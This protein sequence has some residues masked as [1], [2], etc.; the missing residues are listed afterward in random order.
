[1]L[2]LV[3]GATLAVSAGLNAYIPLLGL[4]LLSRFTDVVQL[5]AGWSWLENGWALG[6]LGVLLLIE[7]F[8]DKVPALD[9]VNDVLQ[10]VVRPASGGMVFAAGSASDTFAVPDP[11]S[12]VTSA[13][14]WPFVLGIAIA[15]VPHLLKTIARPVLNA[16]SAGAGT[17]VASFFE[18]VGAVLLT[19]L[20]VIV[21]LVALAGVALI[22]VLLIRRLSRGLRERAAQ[23]PT[24]ISPPV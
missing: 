8:V 11:A 4:G 13:Q 12:F 17:A 15:L 5:P 21:P 10:T 24:P 3:T 14:F 23:R 7:V 18:D 22:L 2:E 19:V 16:L 9:T 6:I 20:A 1:M